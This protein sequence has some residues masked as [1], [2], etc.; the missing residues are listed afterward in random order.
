[1]SVS[2]SHLPSSPT[3]RSSD[4]DAPSPAVLQPPDRCESGDEGFLGVADRTGAYGQSTGV[5]YLHVF[6]LP[7]EWRI[8][9]LVV[10]LPPFGHLRSEEHTSELQSPDHLVC[11]L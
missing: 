3:R 7:R 6:G 2:P 9:G 4:L 11:R 1:R 10:T 8:R 5:Q